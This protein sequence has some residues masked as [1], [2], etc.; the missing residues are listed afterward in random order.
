MFYDN[1]IKPNKTISK[2]IKFSHYKKVNCDTNTISLPITFSPMCYNF[3]IKDGILFDGL[4]VRSLSLR[5]DNAKVGYF[6]PINPPPDNSFIKACWLFSAWGLDFP[7][8]RH[9]IIVYSSMGEFYFNIIHSQSSDLT[10]VEGLVFNQIP[11]IATYRI[12]GV[13]SLI[14]VS[15]EDGMYIWQ[16]PFAFRKV[17]NAPPIKSVCV[18]NDRLFATTFGEARDVLYSDDLDPTNFNIAVNEGG[19]LE[20]PEGYGRCN[21]V[22]TFQG[23][24]F[25]VRDFD[26]VKVVDY[27]NGNN[28][29]LTHLAVGNGRI[30]EDTLC[31]C[32]D[33]IIY[34]STD[35]L[36]EFNGRDS[37]RIDIGINNFL[38][39]VDN[40]DAVAGFA[41]GS[42]YLGCR[43]DYGDVY[44]DEENQSE[45]F[46]NNA[47]VKINV[48]TYDVD[49]LRGHDVIGLYVINDV[50]NCDICASIREPNGH[51]SMGCITN[52]GLYYSTPTVKVCKSPFVDFEMPNKKKFLREITIETQQDISIEVVTEDSA[53][54]YSIQ[55][56][57]YP[58]SI[59]TSVIGKQFA[60]NI[61][62]SS[63]DNKIKPLYVVIEEV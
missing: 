42:Y 22:L 48:D 12:D 1:C 16:Y 32:G 56:A 20:M 31:V 63:A 59:K 57:D 38:I 4:G 21:K 58:Q 62:S 43:L 13:D 17:E 35:G 50:L 39:G 53:K 24:L 52:D 44:E 49:I 8:Y 25:V 36:Y 30:F 46:I 40:Y 19:K 34:L 23:D 37:H 3:T 28:F 9:F 55:G 6:K 60:F 2:S 47:L 51:L 11:K 15:E 27:D 7:N 18:Y 26:I 61:I 5:S 41:N 45:F 54:K 14:L 33:K 29:S 10:K